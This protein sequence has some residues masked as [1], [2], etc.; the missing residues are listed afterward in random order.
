MFN[1]PYWTMSPHPSARLRNEM[2]CNWMIDLMAARKAP[3]NRDSSGSGINSWKVPHHIKLKTH[4]KSVKSSVVPT[5]FPSRTVMHFIHQWRPSLPLP[6]MIFCRS[7]IS[8][9]P[10]GSPRHPMPTSKALTI[11]PCLHPSLTGS[12][13]SPSARTRTSSRPDN[14]CHVSR[15]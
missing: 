14:L 9:L 2:Q 6:T 7:R 8:P 10:L 3:T 12:L 1:P 5:Q 13:P 15:T 4:R 11:C